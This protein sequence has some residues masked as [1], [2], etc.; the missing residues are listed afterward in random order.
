MVL[1]WSQLLC[2]SSQSRCTFAGHL[3]PLLVDRWCWGLSSITI[4]GST[5]FAWLTGTPETGWAQQKQDQG[6]HH[7]SH[8][9]HGEGQVTSTHWPTGTWQFLRALCV[10][11]VGLRLPEQVDEAPHRVLLGA[12]ALARVKAS[13]CHFSP[14]SIHS[15]CMMLRKRSVSLRGP[16]YTAAPHRNQQTADTSTHRLCFV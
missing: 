5:G 15:S 2:S 11:A 7:P 10:C 12:D 14:D 4:V 8:Q 16:S 9:N 1:S 13:L 6:H 3:T